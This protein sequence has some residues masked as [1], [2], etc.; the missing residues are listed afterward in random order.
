MIQAAGR[1]LVGLLVL[2]TLGHWIGA[3]WVTRVAAVGMALVLVIAGVVAVWKGLDE[4]PPLIQPLPRWPEPPPDP[5]PLTYKLD[6][7]SRTYQ[8]PNP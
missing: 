5:E 4:E 1:T 7:A 6:R 3:L 8:D 2:A